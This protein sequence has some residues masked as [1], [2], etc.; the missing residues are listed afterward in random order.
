MHFAVGDVT[1]LLWIVFWRG[2]VD[3]GDLAAT[4]I[5]FFEHVDLFETQRTLPIIKQLNIP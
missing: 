4:V 2:N 1:V 3:E 5:A